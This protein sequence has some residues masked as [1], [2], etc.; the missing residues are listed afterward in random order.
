MKIRFRVYGGLSEKFAKLME[1]EWHH[2]EKGM[3]LA[4]FLEAQN[5]PPKAYWVATVN[6]NIVQEDYLLQDGDTIQIFPPTAGG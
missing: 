4:S 3:S 1:K 6:K 2:F 5:M